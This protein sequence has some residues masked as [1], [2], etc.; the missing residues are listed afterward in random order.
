MLLRWRKACVKAFRKGYDGIKIY[1]MARHE[2]FLSTYAYMLEVFA[3]K[4]LVIL[5]GVYNNTPDAIFNK[6]AY[7]PFHEGGFTAAGFSEYN[8]VLIVVRWRPVK[9]VEY[10]CVVTRAVCFSKLYHCVR[11]SCNKS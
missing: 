8:A 7:H 1:L 3:C 2:A 10:I 5:L 6:P 4:L 9:S 11:F